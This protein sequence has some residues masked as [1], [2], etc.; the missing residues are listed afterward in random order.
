M[1]NLKCPLPHSKGW[2][3]GMG[4]KFKKV[5]DG[6]SRSWQIVSLSRVDVSFH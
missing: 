1:L 4:P 6:H 2:N 3:A 5:M